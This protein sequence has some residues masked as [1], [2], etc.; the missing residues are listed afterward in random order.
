MM[1]NQLRERVFDAYASP[2]VLHKRTADLI[3]S[4]IRSIFD[5]SQISKSGKF[6]PMK[7][8]ALMDSIPE[9]CALRRKGEVRNIVFREKKVFL[10]YLLS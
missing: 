4:L 8:I 10:R 5:R 3:D 9:K 1:P 7:F 2:R 6:D